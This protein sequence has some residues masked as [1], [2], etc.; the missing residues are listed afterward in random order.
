[1]K[2]RCKR[3]GPATSRLPRWSS[4]SSLTPASRWQ[5]A[6]RASVV[7]G[8]LP[9]GALSDP[10]VTS[11]IDLDV[12]THQPTHDVRCQAVADASHGRVWI[13]EN[14][15]HTSAVIPP[16]WAEAAEATAKQVSFAGEV[17]G[18]NEPHF[19]RRPGVSLRVDEGASL[20]P[21]GR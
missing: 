11:A 1:M 17:A 8:A 3:S 19:C 5:K 9:A 2:A 4:L 7:A 16:G 20:C 18:W 21:V 12:I 13:T 15:R 10:I 14:G 6:G